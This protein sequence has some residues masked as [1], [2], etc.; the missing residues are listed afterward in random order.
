MDYSFHPEAAA[1]LESAI[2]HS[3]LIRMLDAQ[4]FQPA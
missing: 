4:Q 1:E 3:H 2:S